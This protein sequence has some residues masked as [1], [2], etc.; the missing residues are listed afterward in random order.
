MAMRDGRPLVL[1]V[2]DHVDNRQRYA[3]FLTFK[4]CQVAEAGDGEA[5]LVTARALQPDVV[6]M[7]L[8]LPGMDGWHALNELKA[9]PRTRRIPVIILTGHAWPLYAERARA[10]GCEAFLTKPCFPEDI[11][12]AVDGA[13]SPA[14]FARPDPA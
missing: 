2:D 9:D 3:K 10:A 5:A 1:I 14:T 6:V 12:Q 11:L 4:G 7:D 13:F 8:T